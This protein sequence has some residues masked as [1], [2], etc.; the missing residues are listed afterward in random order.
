MRT[1]VPW[2]EQAQ[3]AGK[4]DGRRFPGGRLDSAIGENSSRY[5]SVGMCRYMLW[6]PIRPGPV[7]RLKTR[8][9]EPP[10]MPIRRPVTFT[11]I[12]T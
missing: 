5:S 6:M 7:K 11:S 3:L 12:A 9:P 2:A 1:S 8:L 10:R 4:Q